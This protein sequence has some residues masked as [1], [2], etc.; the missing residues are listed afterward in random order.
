M[1]TL[2]KSNA[3]LLAKLLIELKDK[4]VFKLYH[5]FSEKLGVS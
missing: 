3:K 4:L 5:V 1:D 2:F